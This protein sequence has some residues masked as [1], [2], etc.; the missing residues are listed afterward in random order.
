MNAELRSVKTAAEQALADAYAAAKAKLPGD[1]KVAALREAA[2]GAVR[3]AGLPHRRVEEWKYTDLR[4]LLRDAKPLAGAPDAAAK[5]RA[6]D[7]GTL[8][9]DIDARRVVFVD[10]VFAP[11]LSDLDEF[12]A[13]LTIRSMA[14]ALAAGDPLVAAHL[15]KVAPPIARA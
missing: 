5:A 11:E 10:G 14:E 12:S 8:I 15:G 9:G 13:G 1:R 3:R 4:A 7:A 6:K 2:F